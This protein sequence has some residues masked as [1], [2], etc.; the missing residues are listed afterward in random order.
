MSRRGLFSKAK[1]YSARYFALIVAK[2]G[3]GLPAD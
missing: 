2:A 1:A 3:G